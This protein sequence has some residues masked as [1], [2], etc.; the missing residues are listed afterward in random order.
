MLLASYEKCFGRR[1]FCQRMGGVFL[2]VVT[3]TL[4]HVSQKRPSATTLRCVQARLDASALHTYADDAFL[5]PSA[6]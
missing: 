3:L 2:S 5:L 1:P 6:V 4:L